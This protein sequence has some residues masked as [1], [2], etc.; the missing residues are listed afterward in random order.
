MDMT[1]NKINLEIF[2]HISDFCE[3]C[4]EEFD[5]NE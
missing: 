4:Y 2:K 1:K 5:L 3:I